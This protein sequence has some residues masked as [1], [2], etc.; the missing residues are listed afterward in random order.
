MQMRIAVLMGGE[1]PEREVS[2]KTGR[3][4]LAALKNQGLDA[5]EV[6]A[7]GHWEEQLLADKIDRAFVALHGPGGEDGIAQ[8]RLEDIGLAYTGSGPKASAL[9]MNKAN[10]KEIFTL[11]GVP[12]PDFEIVES[13]EAACVV[14]DQFGYPV[15]VK[16]TDQGSA[17]GLTP[18]HELAEIFHAF[19]VARAL[20][21]QVMIEPWIRGRE[22]TVGIV[23]GIALPV[24]EII[25]HQPFNNFDAKYVPGEADFPCPAEIDD[26]TTQRLQVISLKAFEVLGCHGWGRADL[27]LDEQGQPWLLEMNTVPGLTETSLV[28][29]AARAA[30]I[31]YGTLV[32]KILETSCVSRN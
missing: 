22:F 29:I 6:D 1:S 15:V 7:R 4:V 13:V 14:G 24:I 20:S 5:I 9:A 23:G 16:P 28:P 26:A 19:E 11:Q 30:G 27:M 3:G 21:N 8:Q 18:V 2:L 25:P 10:S 17:M 12:T 32:L 31:D